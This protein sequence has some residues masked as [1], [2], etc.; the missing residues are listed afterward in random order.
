MTQALSETI[1]VFVRLLYILIFIRIILSFLQYSRRNIFTDAVQI[2]TEPL[3]APV[4]ALLRKSPLGARGVTPELSPFVLLLI[5]SLARNII[6]GF[7]V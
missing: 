6:V 5:I 3:L 2:L 1:G 7:L 4:R